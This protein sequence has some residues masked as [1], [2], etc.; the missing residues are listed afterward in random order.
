MRD[1]QRG[2]TKINFQGDNRNKLDV[3][4]ENPLAIEDIA[5]RK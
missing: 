1:Q 4:A 2:A 5:R 3:F